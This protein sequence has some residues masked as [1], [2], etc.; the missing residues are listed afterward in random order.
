[1]KL[2]VFA[3]API[4]GQVK[5]RLA[6]ALGAAGAAELHRRLVRH[7]L[8]KALAADI[9]PV[10]LCCAPHTGH[11]FFADCAAEFGVTLT[12]QGEGDL[13]VRMSRVFERDAP[14]LLIG[15]DAPALGA[16]QIVAAAAALDRADVVITPAEDGGYMLIGLRA[17]APEVFAGIAW[18]TSDVA[19]RTRE[20][21][22]ALGLA[23]HEGPLCWD[24]DRPADLA[25]LAELDPALLEN[26]R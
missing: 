24:V 3:K 16:A 26:L 14:A 9:G 6:T 10:E 19:R 23:L 18:S 12:E 13:G 2:V 20:R 21:I 8:R 1:M 15:C 5:T 17:A 22:A 7:T 11:G 25:R 4:P